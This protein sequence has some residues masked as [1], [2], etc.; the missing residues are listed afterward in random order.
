MLRYAA[1]LVVVAA[2]CS[3]GEATA[4]EA[5][6]ADGGRRSS[7]PGGGL[8]AAGEVSEAVAEPAVGA[9][10]RGL[11][12][13]EIEALKKLSAENPELADQS[14]GYISNDELITILLVVLIVVIIF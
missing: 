8:A 12:A 11:R 5:G 2:L 3:V 4:A 9:A 1:L 6:G 14:G 7:L 10:A 13:D